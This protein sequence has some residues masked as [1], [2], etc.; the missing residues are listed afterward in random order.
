MITIIAE[1]DVNI[2]KVE[3]FLEA[4]KPLVEGSNTEAG[5]NRYE[6]HKALDSDNTYTMI[7]EWKDQT[8]IDSHNASD[9]YTSIVPSLG[10]F[11]KGK[12]RVT[13]YS[14]VI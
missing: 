5:C 3:D 10:E 11:M 14:K 9:H 4:V 2:D 6:L 12:P 7:E 1:F 13:L 8:A